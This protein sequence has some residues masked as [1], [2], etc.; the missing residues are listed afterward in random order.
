MLS[1]SL[2]AVLTPEAHSNFRVDGMQHRSFVTL[3]NPSEEV[4]P[5]GNQRW[6]LRRFINRVEPTL[7]GDVACFRV[8]CR[9]DLP[10][11]EGL[12][13]ALASG[14]A[15]GISAVAD[16]A[17]DA[18]AVGAVLSLV[19]DGLQPTIVMHI[20]NSAFFIDLSMGRNCSLSAGA[21]F[22]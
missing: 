8:R 22:A 16:I 10:V 5:E 1:E 2:K 3:S 20:A 17:G 12:A 13:A 21:C 7:G 4:I 15:P 9:F 18:P 11:A 19:V 14:V 6:I